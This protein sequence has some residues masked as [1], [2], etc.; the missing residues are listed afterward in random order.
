MIWGSWFKDEE[1]E[2]KDTVAYLVQSAPHNA[3]YGFDSRQGVYCIGLFN[4]SFTRISSVPSK[5]CST[6]FHDLLNC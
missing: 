5:L 1:D 3:E 2:D 4:K 6:V